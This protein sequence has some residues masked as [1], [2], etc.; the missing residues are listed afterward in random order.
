MDPISALGGSSSQNQ[1]VD[2]AVTTMAA[3]VFQMIFGQMQQIV[4]QFQET[5]Q[6]DEDYPNNYDGF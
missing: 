6:D 3:S 1:A 5:M 2:Q 4:G